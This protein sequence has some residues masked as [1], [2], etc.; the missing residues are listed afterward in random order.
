MDYKKLYEE[1][2]DNPYFDDKTKAE[3]KAIA[4]DENEIKERAD[5]CERYRKI[6]TVLQ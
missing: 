2:L 1:W 5:R 6:Q 4:E 3:L